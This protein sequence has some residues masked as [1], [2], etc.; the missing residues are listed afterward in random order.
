MTDVK[1]IYN[2]FLWSSLVWAFRAINRNFT[3]RQVHKSDLI[4]AFAFGKVTIYASSLAHSS[5]YLRERHCI[6]IYYYPIFS[7]YGFNLARRFPITL[8]WPFA[9]VHSCIKYY[10]AHYV[11]W[12]TP[13]NYTIMKKTQTLILNYEFMRTSNK[14]KLFWL[15]RYMHWQFHFSGNDQFWKS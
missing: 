5:S 15:T 3:L 1:Q 14:W 10:N 9:H 8:P 4:N 6:L 2:F 12:L 7:V 11:S 13:L